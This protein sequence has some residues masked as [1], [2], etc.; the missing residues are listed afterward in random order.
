MRTHLNHGALAAALFGKTRRAI[1]SLLFTHAEES[2]YV[3][4]IAELTGAAL[5]AVPRELGSLTEAGIIL[6]RV[7]GRQVYYRANRECPIFS[8]LRSIIVKTAGVADA[9][10]SALLP[11]AEDITIAFIYGSYARGAETASSDVDVF[12]VGDVDDTAVHVAFREAERQVGR[13]VNYSLFGSREFARRRTEKDGFI[14]RVLKG[15]RIVLLGEL[16]EV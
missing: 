1:L 5:G 3:R 13:A 11:L 2:F 9:L 6:R 7:D 14:A 10:A 8:E 12:V 15:P 16:D 4:R